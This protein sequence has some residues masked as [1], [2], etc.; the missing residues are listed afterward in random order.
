MDNQIRTVLGE[1]GAYLEQ[2]YGGMRMNLSTGETSMVSGAPDEGVRM[3]MR[4]DGT[5][6][7]EHQIGNVHIST[8]RGIE[9]IF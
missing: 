1:H 2:E 3:V 8:D 4:P 7:V 6:A 5:S 9:S